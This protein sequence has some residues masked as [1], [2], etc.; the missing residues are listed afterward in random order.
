MNQSERIAESWTNDRAYLHAVA[1]RILADRVEAED[2][3]QDA[4]ARLAVQSIE[5]INDV[6]AWLVVVVRRLALDR[7]GSAHRRLSRP[8]DPLDLEPGS[9]TEPVA[10]PADRVTLDD[11]VRRA[12]GVVLDRLTPGERT[13]FLLHDVFGVPFDRIAELVG[14]TPGACRQLAR[15][16]RTSITHGSS[17]SAT[18]A[19][20]DPGALLAAE[21]FRAA[22]AG[23]DLEALMEVL[24]PEVSGWASIGGRRAGVTSGIE[25]VAERAMLY[26]GP[27]SGWD[28]SLLP[29]D[30]AVAIVATRRAEPVGLI[31]L[32]VRDSRI[33]AL[34]A[35][36][37]RPRPISVANDL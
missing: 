27:S 19:G 25:P 16:A 9:G 28:L 21:R 11:E 20:T 17:D 26:L 10:D 29:I 14:R 8:S 30:G 13:A 1:V 2:V 4:F 5:T 24:D 33:V 22:C 31:R 32:E 36:I 18:A 35:T 12:L 6:R 34:R 23:G 15:R 7:L 37:V 3:V